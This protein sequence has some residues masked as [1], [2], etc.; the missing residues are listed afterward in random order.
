MG[1]GYRYGIAGLKRDGKKN[2]Y[3]KK[4]G[5]MMVFRF[6]LL[7]LTP[8]MTCGIVGNMS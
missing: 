6:I 5:T 8:V 3:V 4:R 7:N 2:N 1:W